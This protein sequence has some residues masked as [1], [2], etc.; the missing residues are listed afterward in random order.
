MS[1][2]ESSRRLCRRCKPVCVAPIAYH[3]P[4]GVGKPHGEGT[5]GGGIICLTLRVLPEETMIASEEKVAALRA[6]RALNPR[7]EDVVDAR[8]VEGEPFFD[9]RDLVQVKYEMLRRVHM[10]G[11][12]VS[13]AAAAF[14]FSRTSFYAARAA[15]AEEGLPG[16]LARRPGPRCAHKLTEEVL[17]FVV[18][19]RKDQPKCPISLLVPIID[20]RFG[21]VVHPRSVE[22]ALARQDSRPLSPPPNIE[23]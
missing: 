7:P 12:S 19:L 11:Q 2:T 1:A 17:E 10:D 18:R 4:K 6:H 5:S 21:V 13:C 14:G 22:R 3:A 9:A 20:E 8:F 16:L 23:G 15:W